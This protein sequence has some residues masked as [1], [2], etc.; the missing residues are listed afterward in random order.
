MEEMNKYTLKGCGT[1]CLEQHDLQTV[2][3]ENYSRHISSSQ[4]APPIAL[5]EGKF[6]SHQ[7]Q[8]SFTIQGGRT[9]ELIDF[10]VL[11]TAQKSVMMVIL[12]EGKLDFGYDSLN[13]TLDADAAYNAVLVNLNKPASFHRQLYTDNY[14][15]KL[16]IALPIDWLESRCDN[17]DPFRVFLSEHLAHFKLRLDAS[18][19]ALSQ[20]LINLSS[21]VNFMQRMQVESL[22]LQL[23]MAIFKQFKSTDIVGLHASETPKVAQLE[24]RFDHRLDPL[25]VYIEAHLNDPISIQTLSQVSAMSASS[26]QRKFKSTLGCSV[27]TYIRR[28]RLDIAK[29]QLARGAVSITEAAYNAGYRHPSNFTNA[30]KKQFGFSPTQSLKNS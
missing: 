7:V 25:M 13:F 3:S 9:H 6:I 19:L 26:L 1:R 16:N 18:V 28:R 17:N 11:S 20:E 2:I 4:K 15:T 21:P 5:S 14:V 29:Q 8:N 12:L 24:N 22:T 27:N 23:F 30:F 10:Q